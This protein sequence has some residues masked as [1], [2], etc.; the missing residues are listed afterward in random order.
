MKKLLWCLGIIGSLFLQ[1]CDN[2][3]DLTADYKEIMIVYGLLDNSGDTNYIRINKAFLG[4]GNALLF[5]KEADS[6]NYENLEVTLEKYNIGANIPSATY[7]LTKVVNEI[8]KDS[9]MFAYDENILYKLVQPIEANKSYKLKVRNP[10]TGHEATATTVPVNKISFK[11]PLSTAVVMNFEQSVFATPNPIT[12]ITWLPAPYIGAYQLVM[13]FNYHE[14]PVG[15]PSNFEYKSVRT[16]FP[17]IEHQPTFEE[18]AQGISKEEFFGFIVAAIP[19]NDN[20]SRKFIQM[21]FEVLTAGKELLQYYQINKPSS[22]I[23]QKITSYTNVE[24][25][26]GL[27]SSRGKQGLYGLNLNT[28][29]LD[30][31]RDG[32]FTSHLNFE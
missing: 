22:S 23:V 18:V 2:E 13:Y 15:N 5:A 19:Q 20:L 27:F 4:D 21:D 11:Y 3:V 7:T 31:L 12:K 14:Y 25:G 8:V 1:S 16:V 10:A 17:L 24:N 30:S 32:R 28:K 29:T 6:I 26:L 9:G